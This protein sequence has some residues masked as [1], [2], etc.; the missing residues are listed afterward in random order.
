MGAEALG[1]MKAQCTS[2]G[3]WKCGE[4]GVGEWVRAHSYRRRRRGDKMRLSE[5]RNQKTV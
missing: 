1:H 4:V 2:V 3:E 5:G